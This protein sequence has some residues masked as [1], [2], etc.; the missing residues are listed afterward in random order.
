VDNRQSFQDAHYISQG[1]NQILSTK[2]CVLHCWDCEMM[3]Q[4]VICHTVATVMS[5]EK[6]SWIVMGWEKMIC[7]TVNCDRLGENDFSNPGLWQAGGKMICHVGFVTGWEEIIWHTVGNVID[8]EKM[9]CHT[10]GIVMVWERMT[11]DTAGIA[12]GWEKMIYHTVGIEMGWE[13][14]MG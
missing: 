3:G 4:S 2:Y 10:A 14:K 6:M 1:H 7:H 5:W 11:C 13:E 9:I 12:M 8:W